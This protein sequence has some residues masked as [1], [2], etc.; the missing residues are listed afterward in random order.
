[1]GVSSRAV[2]LRYVGLLSQQDKIS[3]DCW[4]DMSL[5]VNKVDSVR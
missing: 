3:Q 5:L 4:L 2:R 1:M